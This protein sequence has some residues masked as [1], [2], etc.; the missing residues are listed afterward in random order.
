MGNIT[1]HLVEPAL[2]W[3]NKI[4]EFVDGTNSIKCVYVG[5]S[6]QFLVSQDLYLFC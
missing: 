2:D 6:D 1:S 5:L 3:Y 4:T